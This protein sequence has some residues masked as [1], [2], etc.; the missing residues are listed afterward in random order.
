MWRL[1]LDIFVK[2]CLIS[3]VNLFLFKVYFLAKYL[4]KMSNSDDTDFM[5]IEQ[6][7]VAIT[8]ANR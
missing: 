6:F 2:R 8:Q 5:L 4:L 3:A 7:S 1:Q